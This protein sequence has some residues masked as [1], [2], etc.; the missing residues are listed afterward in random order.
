MLR[1]DKEKK[2]EGAD[3][4]NTLYTLVKSKL[5]IQHQLNNVQH[6]KRQTTGYISDKSPVMW[7]FITCITMTT[8]NF[9]AS[10]KKKKR[11]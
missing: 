10:L 9:E 4:F 1:K 6:L 11:M 2:Q 8:A 3:S 7:I 5:N